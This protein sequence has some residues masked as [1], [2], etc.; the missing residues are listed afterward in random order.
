MIAGG[1]EGV[2]GGAVAKA[3]DMERKG[4]RQGG[5]LLEGKTRREGGRK[6][7]S[8][9][10]DKSEGRAMAREREGRREGRCQRVGRVEHDGGEPRGSP[11]KSFQRLPEGPGWP[12]SRWKE[13][14]PP[15][16]L[17]KPWAT[18]STST[19][20][21][22]T[23][24]LSLLVQQGSGA[25]WP[26]SGPRAAPGSF[27]PK[28][29]TPGAAEWDGHSPQRSVLWKELPCL[30]LRLL[31]GGPAGGEEKRNVVFESVGG[32]PSSWTLPGGC[33][34][35]PQSRGGGAALE[36]EADREASGEEEGSLPAAPG[37]PGLTL[38]CLAPHHAPGQRGWAPRDE[39]GPSHT[40]GPGDTPGGA[41]AA[42]REGVA[43]GC[44]GPGKKGKGGDAARGRSLQQGRDRGREQGQAGPG[45]R[46]RVA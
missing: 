17:P 14:S 16:L 29:G 36:A 44:G 30:E 21:M 27:S 18:H 26:H 20:A 13:A 23:P 41:P 34:G 37:R 2:D 10:G 5:L 25:L 31:S 9:V 38:G 43:E 42:G 39:T 45:K 4:R 22:G 35:T 19:G 7:G 12:R 24:D 28:E 32:E 15:A 11:L 40:Q 46:K 6:E 3:R 8:K 33:L 1:G